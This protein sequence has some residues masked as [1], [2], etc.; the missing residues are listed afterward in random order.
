MTDVDGVKDA[1]GNLVNS[2]TDDDIRVRIKAG[3]LTGGMI[4]KVECCLEA[5][6]H[7]V[8]KAHIINGCQEHALLL[9]LFTASG[10]GTEI[11]LK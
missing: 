6:N 3:S 5:L 8:Q 7:G 1:D 10:V 4:P 2:L 9:E 11:T